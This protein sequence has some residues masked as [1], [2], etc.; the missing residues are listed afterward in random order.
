MS[1]A[2]QHLCDAGKLLVVGTSLAV[3]PVAS[4]LK[5]AHYMGEKVLIAKE[6]PETMP[7]RFQFACGNAATL[8]PR[9]VERWVVS[10][11]AP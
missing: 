1:V 11:R 2:R 4:L 8:V 9:L 3:Q 10:R 7:A 6:R 5:A